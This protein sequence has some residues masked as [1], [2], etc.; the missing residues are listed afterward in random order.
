M[1]QNIKKL[2]RIASKKS[3]VIIG[4]MS[5]TSLDGLDVALCRI[6][7]TGQ[8][9]KLKLV[10]FE[11]VPYPAATKSKVLQV[12]AKQQVD[13]Q[14]LCELNAWIG[15]RHAEMVLGCLQKWKLKPKDIDLL[16]SHGQTVFHSPKAITAGAEINSTF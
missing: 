2:Q 14:K 7:G 10:A 8:N 13:F 1:N 5:G 3:R 12:F 11:T 4:L 6:A 9:T 16:A 15:I